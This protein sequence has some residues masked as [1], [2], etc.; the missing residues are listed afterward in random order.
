[1]IKGWKNDPAWRDY[2]DKKAKER[3]QNADACYEVM[4]ETIKLAQIE[5]HRQ[6]SWRN[7][8]SVPN[9]SKDQ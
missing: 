7:K 9:G 4:A 2:F 5:N 6:E 3:A 8:I 1:M